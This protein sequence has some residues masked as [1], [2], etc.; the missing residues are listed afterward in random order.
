MAERKKVVAN[1]KL[2]ASAPSLEA[3]NKLANKYFYGVVT[4]REDGTILNASGTG[5]VKNVKWKKE[6]SR[7]KLYYTIKPN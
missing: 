2:V 3:L 1:E 5:S 7:F 4:L 6:K